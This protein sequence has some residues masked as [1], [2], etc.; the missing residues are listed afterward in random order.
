MTSEAAGIL[1]LTSGEGTIR[2]GGVADF[3]V[4]EHKDQSPA[5]ALVRLRPDLVILNGRVKL[6]SARMADRLR[7]CGT[8]GFEAIH[9]EGR[10]RLYVA[11]RV[12][13]FAD[14]VK[15]HLGENFRLAGKKV[16]A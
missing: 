15:R 8:G 16:M 2:E 1:R 10:G 7:F 9:L 4:V 13:A 12:A 6:F 14:R 11:Y 3:V 5:E